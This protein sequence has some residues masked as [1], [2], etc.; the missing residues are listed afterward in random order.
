[1]A[2]GVVVVGV[3]VGV[4]VTVPGPKRLTSV[5]LFHVVEPPAFSV[6]PWPTKRTYRAGWSAMS[7]S[8]S[9]VVV[10]VDWPENAVAQLVPSLDT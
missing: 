2:V 9:W 8:S 10:P 6:A 5:R 3:G 1:V 4:T 7:Y